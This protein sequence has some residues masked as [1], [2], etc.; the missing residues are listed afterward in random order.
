MEMRIGAWDTLAVAPKPDADP[1]AQAMW[2]Y[3]RALAF[4]AKGRAAEAQSERA[5]FDKLRVTLDRKT[6]WGNNPIGDVVDFASVALDA[7][8]EPSAAAAVAKWKRA[9]EMQDALAYDE[10]PA[11]FCPV[12][13]SLGAAMLLAGDAAGAEA[14]FREG[15]RRSPKNGRMLFGL[16][17]SLKAQNKAEAAAWVDREFQAAWKGAD[18]QLRL[19]DL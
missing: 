15:L 11:W 1:T 8:L 18:V 19:K 10:P 3:S 5:E 17:E 14:V 7:R 12:R 6:P 9:V 16:L 2:R 4:A 13:E